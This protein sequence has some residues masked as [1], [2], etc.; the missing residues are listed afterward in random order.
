MKKIF[1]CLGTLLFDAIV[2]YLLWLL[3]YWITPYIMGVGWFLF[4]LYIFLAGGLIS[5]IAA[6]ING[7]LSLPM[8]FLVKDNIVAKVINVFPLLFFGYSSV[9][10]PWEFNMSYGVLQYIIGISLTIIILISFVG[11]MIIPFRIEEIQ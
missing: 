9:R 3:F 5:C 10:L 4:F 1:K 11:M 7:L 2:G 6:S 8:S